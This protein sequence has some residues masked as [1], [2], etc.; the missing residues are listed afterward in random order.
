M[1]T[2]DIKRRDAAQLLM[3]IAKLVGR[4]K[5]DRHLT[6]DATLQQIEERLMAHG[7]ELPQPC[8][9]EAHSNPYIDNCSVCMPDWGWVGKEVKVK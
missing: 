6:H 1:K 9:G 3:D 7:I 8:P 5:V 4:A 2:Q